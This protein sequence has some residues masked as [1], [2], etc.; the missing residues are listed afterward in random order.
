M[1]ATFTVALIIPRAFTDESGRGDGPFLFAGAYFLIRALHLL[2]QW[3]AARDDPAQRRQLLRFTAP[4]LVATGLLVVAG[5]V[6]RQFFGI[7]QSTV[8]T[9][10]WVLAVAVEYGV[11]FVLGVWGW[12]VASAGHWVER[13]ELI[14]IIAL[15]ETIISVGIGS[16]LTGRPVT[17]A[18]FGGAVLSVSLT[19][20]LWWAYFD[21]VALAAQR[22]MY[23]AHGRH[24]VALARD[25]YIYLHLP[26]IA[27][28]VLFA[29]GGE[30]LLRHLGRS[31]VGLDEPQP[32]LGVILTYSGVI[33]FLL[34]HFAFQLRSLHT[35]A[36]TRL[37]TIAL[38]AALIP[39]AVH[40]P[41]LAALAML[42]TVCVV[43]IAAEVALFAN[44][45]RAL[46]EVSLHE[47]AEHEVRETA[48]RRGRR[49]RR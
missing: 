45:R 38:L 32:G 13:F 19:A 14:V 20:T 39:A 36:W 44:T 30:E 26:M 9:V 33:L 1:A 17:G 16:D 49:G 18:V 46:R 31:G 47:T 6:P 42:T 3:Q 5:F 23:A 24:R 28:L 27:A 8:R 37:V 12:T 4:L 41:A 10:L 48:W 2:L 21:I 15:G 35:I 29:L 22:A 7:D 11:G 43:F 40:L 25:A 34:G